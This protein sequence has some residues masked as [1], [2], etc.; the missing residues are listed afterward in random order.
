MEIAGYEVEPKALALGG[1]AIAGLVVMLAKGRNSGAE[2]QTATLRPA[3]GLTWA[4]VI[5]NPKDRGVIAGPGEPGAPGPPGAP[6]LPGTPGTPGTGSSGDPVVDQDTDRRRR[7]R[8]GRGNGG[9][10]DRGDRGDGKGR[11]DR[12]DDRLGGRGNNRDD[13]NRPDP[14]DRPDRDRGDGLRGNRGKPTQGN[15]QDPVRVDDPRLDDPKRAERRRKGREG[16]RDD[17]RG[18]GRGD[19]DIDVSGGRERDKGKRAN[20]NADGGRAHVGNVGPNTSGRIDASGGRAKADA[21]GGNGNRTGQ[22]AKR[23]AKK[24]LGRGGAAFAGDDP[25]YENGHGRRDGRAGAASL[26]VNTHPNLGGS[27]GGFFGRPNPLRGPSD[28]IV[29][30]EG[31]TLSGIARR[32]Y[33]S[34]GKVERLYRLNEGVLLGGNRILRA[35]TVLKV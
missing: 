2:E 33:G 14:R 29:V 6:G 4:D 27:I 20:A 5:A 12:R 13:R 19:F 34:T 26:E 16:L 18:D 21:S 28:V 11:G 7:R 17:K 10:D 1:A 8:P 35:G 3:D 15:R 23:A 31:D 9:R 30:K 32:A 24:R 22:D 25:L